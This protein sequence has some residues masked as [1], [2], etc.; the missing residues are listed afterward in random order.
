MPIGKPELPS[1]M[2]LKAYKGGLDLVG[3]DGDPE[4]WFIAPSFRAKGTLFEKRD[5]DLE[6]SVSKACSSSNVS[7]LKYLSS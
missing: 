4:G 1:P 3:P 2:R 6:C 7:E 5:V